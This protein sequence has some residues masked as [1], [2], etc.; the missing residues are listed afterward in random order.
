MSP[1]GKPGGRM[2]QYSACVVPFLERTT[3]FVRLV[4]RISRSG[5]H[6]TVRLWRVGFMPET[7]PP[8]LAANL[9]SASDSA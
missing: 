9:S 6:R 5:L 8:V 4:L 2:L 7:C 1:M 3:F